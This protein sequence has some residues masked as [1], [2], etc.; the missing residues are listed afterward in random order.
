M[1]LRKSTTYAV[2]A[3]V[4]MAGMV[5]FSPPVA[6]QSNSADVL[7]QARAKAREMEE[8]KS[9]LNGP[10]QNMRLSV[11]DIMVNSGDEAMRQVAIDTGL[12]S[13]DSLMQAMALKEAIFSLDRI[14]F[15]L[16]VDS[17][18]SVELQN[19]AKKF[20]E[21]QGDTFTIA[22]FKPD[23]KTGVFKTARAANAPQNGQVHG[24]MVTIDS[25]RSKGNFSLIDDSTLQGPMIFTVGSRDSA[26]FIATAKIR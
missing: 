13:T 1:S 8:L 9:V 25:P 23:P 26:G 24:T 14:V 20:L 6:A 17:S 15:T 5:S 22:V 18:Q 2:L 10:D 19:Q 21:T 12:A 16:E 3:S 4:L 11:F 7:E